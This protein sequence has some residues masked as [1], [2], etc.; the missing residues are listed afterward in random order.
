MITPL[1]YLEKISP[2]KENQR[3]RE[4]LKGKRGKTRQAPRD[5]K[6]G[7]L[8]KRRLVMAP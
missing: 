1:R 5:P 6:E 8:P 2:E 4:E 3:L 7:T